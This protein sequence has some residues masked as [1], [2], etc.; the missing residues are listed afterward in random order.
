[1]AFGTLGPN[2]QSYSRSTLARCLRRRTE[3]STVSEVD[4]LLIRIS[5]Y[6]TSRFST[7]STSSSTGMIVTPSSVLIKGAG[8]LTV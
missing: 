3:I 1:M 4:R 6:N 2:R 8:P 7:T 5:R